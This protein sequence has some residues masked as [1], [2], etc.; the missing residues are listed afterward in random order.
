MSIDEFIAGNA[1][2]EFDAARVHAKIKA[3]N[4]EIA[5]MLLKMGY[6]RARLES[7]HADF[8]KQCRKYHH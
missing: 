3:S 2:L 8:M 5:A 1:I 7:T 4:E 6:D